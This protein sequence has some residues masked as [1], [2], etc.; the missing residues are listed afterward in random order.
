VNCV[1]AAVLQGVKGIA[2]LLILE[3][4]ANTLS[5]NVGNQL[6]IYAAQHPNAEHKPSLTDIP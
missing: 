6:P 4:A 5:Q 1:K 2:E 3:D